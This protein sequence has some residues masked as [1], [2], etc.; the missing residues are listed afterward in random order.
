MLFG[1]VP[2]T[3]ATV[4]KRLKENGAILLAK[5]NMDEFGMGSAN[6][7]SYFGPSIN[8]WSSSSPFDSTSPQPLSPSSPPSPPPPPT[9]NSGEVYVTGGSSG[10]SAA[11]VASF[12]CFASIGSDT[13]GSVRMPAAYCGV[14]GLKP[15]Y[16]RIS[17]FG[18]ISYASSLDCPGI[19][20]RSV[21]D[22]ALLLDT[23]SGHDVSDSTSLPLPPTNTKPNL[24]DN[25]GHVTIGIPQ[26]IEEMEMSEEVREMWREMQERMRDNFNFRVKRISLPSLPF[27]L[28]AY[29]LI[30]CGEAASN[31]SRYDGVRY[32]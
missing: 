18:L 25:L 21:N 2:P 32:V 23:I 30:A 6:L 9:E 13:G 1:F 28:S 26:E 7:H 16:G 5:A 3:D 24:C 12:A 17:R 27:S 20:S 14:I 29:Y 10:G 31:L 22:I 8:P 15:S 11:A 4:V 19:F